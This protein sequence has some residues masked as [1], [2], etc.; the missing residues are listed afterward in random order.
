MFSIDDVDLT[1][2]ITLISNAV[3]AF[4]K[5]TGLVIYAINT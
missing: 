3:E 5:L 2:A 1:L 4:V